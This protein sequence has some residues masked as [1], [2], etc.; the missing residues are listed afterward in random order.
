ML[1]P[2]LQPSKPKRHGEH[3]FDRDPERSEKAIH[4]ELL[5]IGIGAAIVW[6]VVVAFVSILFQSVWPIVVG[7]V[8]AAALLWG[9]RA[10]WRKLQRRA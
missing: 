10:I 6:F 8:L 4:L 3:A 2:W 9:V 5:A 1:P 7:V